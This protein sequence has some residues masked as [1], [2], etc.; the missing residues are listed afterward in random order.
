MNDSVGGNISAN[1]P[2][3][4]DG[5][6]RAHRAL[7][8]LYALLLSLML[9]A[10]GWAVMDGAS[11]F[12]LFP[13]A[14]GLMIFG[15]IATAHGFAARGARLGKPW[16]R[17]LSRVVGV[18]LLFGFPVGTLIGIYILIQ[19]GSNRWHGGEEHGGT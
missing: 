15:P 18:L 5:L 11:G 6:Y 8:V 9:L 10:C 17:T 13:L 3:L 16:G 14:M 2:R 12:G 7:F 1:Q 4:N 19:T